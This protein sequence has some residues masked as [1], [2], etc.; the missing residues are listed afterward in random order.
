MVVAVYTHG[1]REGEEELE[2]KVRA[3]GLSIAT[4]IDETRERILTRRKLAWAAAASGPP[5]PPPPPP[6]DYIAPG[7]SRD[8]CTVIK[9]RDSGSNTAASGA[10]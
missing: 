1:G 8:I 10:T 9:I 4:L 2:K 6:R 3:S 7:S 5:L